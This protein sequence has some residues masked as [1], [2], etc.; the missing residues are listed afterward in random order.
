MA[1]TAQDALDVLD[2]DGG[3]IDMIVMDFQL[4]ANNGVE[5][6]HEIRSYDDWA[7]IP[8]IVLSSIPSNRVDEKRLGSYGVHRLLYKPH[9]SPRELLR[10]VSRAL[11]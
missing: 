8:A 3:N 5:F 7:S 4:G 10:Q 11:S 6:L 2:E 1:L 9:T